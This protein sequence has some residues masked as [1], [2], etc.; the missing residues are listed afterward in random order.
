MISDFGE[1]NQNGAISYSEDD[2]R[3]ASELSIPLNIL[4]WSYP[5]N[6]VLFRS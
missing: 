1:I 4:P 6:E 3:A 2:F 5:K